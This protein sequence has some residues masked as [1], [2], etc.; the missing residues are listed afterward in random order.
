MVNI[1]IKQ[2]VES[3]YSL[4]HSKTNFSK[5]DPIFSLSSEYGFI[6]LLN[7]TLPGWGW[8]SEKASEWNGAQ[9][10]NNQVKNLDRT[11]FILPTNYEMDS[12]YRAF[13]QS[14]NI[15]FPDNY[16][17]LGDIPYSMLGA[18]RPLTIYA[19]KS[20]LN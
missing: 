14:R 4:I 15:G 10:K 16:T 2:S 13:F 5:G 18:D 20:I 3:A 19:P 7:G 6:Y 1:A 11:I 9:L 17:K 8:Y 12:V